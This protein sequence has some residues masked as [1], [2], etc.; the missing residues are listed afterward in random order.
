[1]GE[2]F[3]IAVWIVSALGPF[4]SH[5][6]RGE[7]ERSREGWFPRAARY[8]SVM[9]EATAPLYPFPLLFPSYRARRSW[10]ASLFTAGLAKKHRRA[11]SR[12]AIFFLFHARQ[13]WQKEYSSEFCGRLRQI[14]LFW[15]AAMRKKEAL[16][17]SCMDASLR[18]CYASAFRKVALL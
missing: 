17:G 3:V 13:K 6:S 7:N 14:D 2:P 1:M 11:T 8:S 4:R 10:R 15:V 12:H 16:R 9:Q 18:C 5:A